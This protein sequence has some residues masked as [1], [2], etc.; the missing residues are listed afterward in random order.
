MDGDWSEGLARSRLDGERSLWYPEVERAS[1]LRGEIHPRRP[2]VNGAGT[3]ERS[4]Y[5]SKELA[6]S[7]LNSS[8]SP[9]GASAVVNW[10]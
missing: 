9:T 3:T 1:E 6:T 2:V 4:D 5:V 7:F 8:A 10:P